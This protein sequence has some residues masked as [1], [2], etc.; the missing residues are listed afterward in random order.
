MPV[1]LES[2]G[3]DLHEAMPESAAILL[4]VSTGQGVQIP[5]LLSFL[6]WPA[7]HMVHDKAPS[8]PVYPELHLQSFLP[9]LPAPEFCVLWQSSQTLAALPEYLPC[10]QVIHS[11]CS[12]DAMIAFAVPAGHERQFSC[13][14]LMVPCAYLPR[15]HDIHCDRLSA[16]VSS[17]NLPVYATE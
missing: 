5:G 6:Y 15:T 10:R 3:H 4:Y 8:G 13:K 17:R 9:V 11:L 7:V 14:V 12:F 1:V 2:R 16:P